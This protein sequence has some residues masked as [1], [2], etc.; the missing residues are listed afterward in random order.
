[1]MPRRRSRYVLFVA[2][3]MVFML[4]QV[5]KSP[6][7]DDTA[8]PS[9]LKP[10]EPE[11]GQAVHKEPAKPPSVN[12]PASNKYL[13]N[14]PPP[15]H[16]HP[17][18]QEEDEPEQNPQKQT[19]R[20][21]V[22]IPQLK[23]EKV[24]SAPPTETLS[25]PTLSIHAPNEAVEVTE[26]PEVTKGPTSSLDDDIHP[27]KPPRRPNLDRSED[28]SISTSRVHWHKVSEHFPVPTGEIIP[29]PTGKPKDIPKIQYAFKPETDSAKEKREKR[30]ALV[31]AE[32]ERSWTGY[33]KFAWTH[34]ELS[35][36]TGRFRDPFCGWAATLV[37]GLDTLWIMGMKEDFDAAAKAVKDID[38][39]FSPTRRDIPVFETIIRYLGGL[40][41]A[42]DVSGGKKG[43]Y[44]VLLDKALELADILMGVFDT[45]NRMPI[46]YYN[47]EPQYAS[48]PHRATTVGVAEL[49]TM[50]MEFTRLA[51]LTGEDKYYDAIARIT[52]AF[53]DLQNR[54]TA[55]DGIFPE[56]LD[57][58]GCNRTAEAIAYQEEQVAAASASA[59][60]ARLGKSKEREPAAVQETFLAKGY[61]SESEANLIA[62][63]A[64][65]V[66]KDGETVVENAKDI[67][68]K[69][70]FP[71]PKVNE[72][73]IY[74]G[75]SG[76]R[77]SPTTPDKSSWECI[78]QGLAPGG[79]GNQQYSMGGSQDSTY[80]YFPKEYLVLGGLE[81]KYKT[82]HI[83]TVE[84]VKKWLLYRPMVPKERDI[85]FS[86]K[87]STS[88]D[89]EN[90]LQTEYEV[91]HLTCFI[92]GMFGLGGKIFD[93]PEDVEIAKK[94]TDGCVWAYESMPSGIMPEAASVVPCASTQSC[95]WNETLWWEHMDPSADWR[96]AQVKAW[97][98]KQREK[99]KQEQNELRKQSVERSK[100][101]LTDRNPTGKLN[102]EETPLSEKKDPFAGI[103]ITKDEPRKLG[104][105]KKTDYPAPEPG[106]NKSPSIVDEH[107]LKKRDPAPPTSKDPRKTS[108]DEAANHSLKDKLDLNS[109]ENTDSVSNNAPASGGIVGKIKFEE[110]AES[111]DPK[112]LTHE[113]Y[114]KDKLK[115]EN[116]PPGFVNI[117]SQRYILRP[118]AIESVWYMY[119]ITGDP[120]WQEKGWRMWEAII[121]ATRTEYGNSAVDNVL[122]EEPRPV[123]E[124]ESFWVAETLKYFYL[125]FSTPDVIS[126]D[127]WVLNTE[128]HPFKRPV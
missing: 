100:A 33:R 92:G 70:A 20:P 56:Q 107:F 64:V 65:G 85:L 111:P 37:D 87:V 93:R 49:G 112:P 15:D 47:W 124:M 95:P 115:R 126:L 78:K 51:Q 122:L 73:P 63:R 17:H 96:R 99:K 21:T 29:L 11:K 58:S 110:E 57:A 62:K 23:T 16:E 74:P 72:Q 28:Q 79:W 120:E 52:N 81:P 105:A 66:G 103:H 14:N 106:L 5:L 38:F 8:N 7:W 68:K 24:K 71:E 26:K 36:V 98:E 101:D 91:T 67:D 119:R 35:P 59:A 53:E 18:D 76:R 89:P 27:K 19:A 108:A 88:G 4:Y 43:E 22:K 40:L 32:M 80:E 94:L 104:S 97:E 69:Q 90:D 82:M 75:N 42:Y 83:K 12:D 102:E 6:E 118:E 50:S 2:I 84:A 44:K 13:N 109:A 77:P 116:I 34:D 30:L 127:D 31:K 86:A 55:I 125:L 41:A 25:G 54:G 117:N 48:Q 61:G 121:K 128:A 113:E 60:A 39:T 3:V 46:L 10:S 1:M 45:P 114:I 123:D 9:T